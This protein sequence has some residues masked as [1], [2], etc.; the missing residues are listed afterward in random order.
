MTYLTTITS[1]GQLTLPHAIRKRLG[2]KPGDRAIVSAVSPRKHQVTFKIT[3]SNA[4]EELYGSL[5]TNIPYVPL[6]KVRAVAG[7]R[8]GKKY[9]IK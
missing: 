4:V 8:L 3:S 1:R 6:K 7:Y 5:A 2:V 9:A